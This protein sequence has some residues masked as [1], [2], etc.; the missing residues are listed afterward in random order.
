MSTHSRLA[1]SPPLAAADDDD[2]EEE[3]AALWPKDSPFLASPPSPLLPRGDGL[4]GG[5]P[6]AALGVVFLVGV[7]CVLKGDFRGVLRALE[8]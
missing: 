3:E 6:L 2:A 1:A 5:V 4:P 8:R 7:A